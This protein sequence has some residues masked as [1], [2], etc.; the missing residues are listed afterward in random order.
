MRA[1]Q[2]FK[3]IRGDAPEYL[4]LSFT[5]ASDARLLRSSS[6]SQLYTPNIHLKKN[7]EIP[8]YFHPG[9]EFFSFIYP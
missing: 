2:I 4:R 9:L 7:I 8:L 1:I 3:T 5:V 6:S